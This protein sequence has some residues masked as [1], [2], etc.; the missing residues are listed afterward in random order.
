MGR[1]HRRAVLERGRSAPAHSMAAS[2]T[3]PSPFALLHR[4]ARLPPPASPASSLTFTPFFSQP[5]AIK[6]S[7]FDP[8]LLH[9]SSCCAGQADG[10]RGRAAGGA[11]AR[12]GAVGQG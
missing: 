9:P 11:A 1:L 2:G 6:R 7:L 10:A 5:T 3:E 4:V 12:E 8:F